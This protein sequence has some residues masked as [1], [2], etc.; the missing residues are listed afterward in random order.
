MKKLLFFI[1][2]VGAAAA[3]EYFE[4]VPFTIFS[5]NRYVF[6]LPAVTDFLNSLQ[7]GLTGLTYQYIFGG[8]ELLIALILLPRKFLKGSLLLKI[9][10]IA[11]A[12][13]LIYD[14]AHILYQLVF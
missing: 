6:D 11:A 7:L 13:Y 2:L 3:V 1:L 10:F 9:V 4:L 5:L 14:G 12:V 8:V